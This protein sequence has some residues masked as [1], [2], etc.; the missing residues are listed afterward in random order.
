[1]PDLPC[2]FA[3][4][5]AEELEFTV[6]RA[7]AGLMVML[8][9]G[10]SIAT[11][12]LW[13]GRIR[14]N[15]DIFP[16]AT[17][18][19]LIVP[20]PLLIAGLVLTVLMSLMVL[21]TTVAGTE[22]DA[23]KA[24]A[25]A[26]EADEAAASAQADT[27][28]NAE[29]EADM[30]RMMIDTLS[31]NLM[32]FSVFG[33]VIWLHQQHHSRMQTHTAD[34]SYKSP[35]N[36]AFADT[37]DFVVAG[38][39]PYRAPGVNIEVSPGPPNPFIDAGHSVSANGMSAEPWRFAGEFRFAAEAVLVA[40][41]PTAMLRIFILSLL[42]ESPSHPFLEIMEQGAHWPILVVIA[43]MAIVVAPAVEELLYRVTILGGFMQQNASITGW[44]VSS[45]L[46][47]FAH[48]FPDSIALLPLAF[49]I[50]YTYIRRRSYRTV[51]LV[52]LLFNAFNMV[53]ALISFV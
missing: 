17:R 28:A 2:L 11:I 47:G 10:G 21:S 9:M 49:V 30:L 14:E 24:A 44:I 4:I 26:E 33:L 19:P 41:L 48:G 40:Y 22:S 1:M 3:E 23:G 20:G 50:G 32:M 35:A 45:V 25:M 34:L 5:A 36:E 27:A 8:A 31:M 12:A 13:G 37:T 53:I 15:R 38:H 51:M 52:H 39:D 46:F 29:A 43:A 7:L 42:P 6:G 16:A 18:K